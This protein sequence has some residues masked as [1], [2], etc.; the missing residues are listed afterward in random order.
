MK[1]KP[2]ADACLSNLFMRAKFIFR[3]AELQIIVFVL[4][5]TIAGTSSAQQVCTC[6]NADFEQGTLSGWQGQTGTCCPVNTPVNGIVPGRH[7]IMTGS[8]TDPNACNQ[9]TYVAPG[10]TFSARLGNSS[11]GAQAEKLFYSIAVTTNTALFIYK[12]AVVLE[13]PSHAP[14]DQPRFGVR[15]LDSGGQVVDPT[16]GK[17]DVVASGSIPGFQSCGG[18]VRYKTWT[19]V[20]MD[21]TP[22]IG[23][24]LSIEFSTGDCSQGGHFG[25]AYIDCFCSPLVINTAYCIGDIYAILTAPDGF[26]YLWSTG[27]TTQTISI[28]TPTIG[29]TFSCV[30]TSVTGCQVTLTT[31]LQ[32]VNPFAGFKTNGNCFNNVIFNDTTT[33][34]ANT[35][36]NSWLW[37][38]GDGSTSTQQ[39]PT[40]TYTSIGNYNVKLIVGNSAGCKDSITQQ[41][42]TI[43]IPVITVNSA[44]ICSGQTASLTANGA[45]SFTWTAGATTTGVNTA[46]A[47]PTTTSSYTVTGTSSGCSGTAVAAVSVNPLPTATISGST[48]VCKNA[49]SPNVTFTGAAGTAPYTFTYT[50]N[51]G[52][53]Q[54]ISTTNGNTVT[55]PVSTAVVDTFTYTLVN[56][57]DASSTACTQTQSGNAVVIVNPV[58]SATISGTTAV[59]VGFASPNIYLTGAAG[60]AP[61]TFI[62]TINGGSNHTVSTT[63]GNSVNVSVPTNASGVFTYALV[64]VQDAGSTGCF[65]LQSGSATVTVNPLPTATIAGTTGVCKNSSAPNVTFTAAAGTAPYTF[66]YTINGGSNQTISTTNGNLVAIPVSTA[67]LGIYTYTL[68]DVTDASS[69]S[70]SQLQSGSATVTVNTLPVA[71]FNFTNVCLHKAMYF[72]DTS[73]VA[74]GYVTG[75]SWGFGDSSA[76]ATTQNPTYVYANPGT[77]NVSLIATTNNGCTD[78]TA[79]SAVVYPLPDIQF[80]TANVCDGNVVYFNDASSIPQPD[81]LH[82]R[83]WDFDDG[84]PF[85]VDQNTSH[86]YAAPGAYQVELSIVSDL[87]CSD[88]IT[89]TSFVNPNPVVDFIAND[90]AGCSPKCINVTDL[91]TIS[92]GSNVVQLWNFGDGN[93]GTEPSHCYTNDSA[94]SANYFNVILTVTSDS[95]CVTTK[96]KSNFIMVY[97]N[98]SALFSVNL[99]DLNLPDDE[100]ICTNQSVG[101]SIY[102]WSFGDGGTSTLTD[103]HHAFTTVGALQIQLIAS[104]PYGC[105]DTSQLEVTANA[106]VIFPNAFTPSI[107]GSSGGEYNKEALDNDVFFPY[108]YGVIEFKLEIFDRWGELIFESFDIKKGWD[109]YFKGRLCQQGVYVWK[110]YVKLNNGKVFNKSGSVTLLDQIF[111]TSP[112][113]PLHAPTAEA[114][115]QA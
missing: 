69:T 22:Y 37:N 72:S 108:T 6:A 71:D 87:G 85:T 100:L 70:C 89:K 113:A 45:V 55:L 43:T 7:T 103:P 115:A 109:G 13:D 105:S 92:T 77:Y 2:G 5:F 26:S 10:G 95:G 97:P 36:T 34:P 14:A 98:P 31:I 40:H 91:S 21:L 27:A 11:T 53:N 66:T 76:L 35:T 102:N 19:T 82:S 15:I 17:Y 73:T 81:S 52:S 29:Q 64:S 25:Y 114:S 56:V 16:C 38:F 60:V 99:T 90:T 41:I 94:N 68:L 42:T 107:N 8:G 79:K 104:T 54:T 44:T 57:A 75:W 28:Y 49:T 50:I 83:A 46:S 18:S 112:P 63:S 30:L 88:S 111:L 1:D 58:P 32:P 106:D 96:S 61:Y 23:Q 74:G 20:G 24:N 9:I 110:A 4:T 78:T 65:P 48:S 33:T 59:C 3:R 86:L 12:Y 80:S 39:N 93:F 47:S 62:Y 101:A 51:G 67:T 84:S